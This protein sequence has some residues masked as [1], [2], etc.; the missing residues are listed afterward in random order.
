M[1]RTQI[2]LTE[3][4]SRILKRMALDR[5]VSMAELIRQ[6]VDQFVGSSGELAPEQIRQRALSVIGIGFSGVTDLGQEHDHYLDEVYGD[7]DA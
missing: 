4:Q 5:D 6:S 2:Q 3:E 7:S 1:V